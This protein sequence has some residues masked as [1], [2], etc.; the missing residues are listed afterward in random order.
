MLIGQKLG[1]YSLEKELGSGAMGTVYRARSDKT[2]QRVAIKVL[3]F[4]LGQNKKARERFEREIDVLSQL[5]HPNIVKYV[6]HGRYQGTEYVA[7]EFIDGETLDGVMHRRGRFTWEE[8][9]EKGRQV[10]SALQHAHHQGIV[11]RDLKPSN[12]M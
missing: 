2:G 4:G 8:V 3:S 7:M 12:L 11:H 5:D 6:N 9:V 1:S 10:C